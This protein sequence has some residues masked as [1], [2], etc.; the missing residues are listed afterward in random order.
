MVGASG[1]SVNHAV[2]SAVPWN[3]KRY[4]SALNY[5]VLVPVSDL[6][7]NRGRERTSHCHLLMQN[8]SE[9]FPRKSQYCLQSVQ[10]NHPWTEQ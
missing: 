5:V 9:R 8:E 1:K 10:G 4:V 3:R 7:A 6:A 2:V